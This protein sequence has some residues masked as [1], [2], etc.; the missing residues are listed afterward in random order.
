MPI[1]RSV[2]NFAFLLLSFTFACSLCAQNFDLKYEL[3]DILRIDSK[4]KASDFSEWTQ[5]ARP[6]ILEAMDA[7]YG[8]EP[9]SKNFKITH[10]IRERSDSALN[11]LAKRVQLRIKI[12]ADCGEKFLDLLVYIPKKAA[13]PAPV[14]LAISGSENF[15]VADDFSILASSSNISSPA[16][17]KG[18]GADSAMWCVE[19]IL[20]RGYAFAIF[21]ATSL[22]ADSKSGAKNSIYKISKNQPDDENCGAISAWAWGAKIAFEAFK[23]I[24]DADSSRVALLGH[25]RFAKAALIASARYPLFKLTILNNSGCM[26]A[27]LSRRV[28][29]ETIASITKSFPYWFSENLKNY[30]YKEFNLPLEQSEIIALIAPRYVYV[31]SASEDSWAD[32]E[33]E[34][35]SLMEA[36]KIYALKGKFNFPTNQDFKAG[37][38]FLGDCAWHLRMGP[39]GLTSYDWNFFMDFADQCM[40]AP[41]F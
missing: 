39:H 14:F 10:L 36:G 20:K 17:A 3:E 24:D 28:Q 33:G 35:L 26:G 2:F 12:E 4:S 25:S 22:F 27:A 18:R 6:R 41:E 32:P 19:N 8:P 31:A 30:A 23:N 7:L 38:S 34:F 11:G 13:L 5:K 21:D 40:F 37:N 29:G 9:N 1:L 16:I 15:R